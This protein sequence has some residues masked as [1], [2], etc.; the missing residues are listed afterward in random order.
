[1][2][3]YDKLLDQDYRFE[4]NHYLNE[5]WRLF[6]KGAGSFIGFTVLFFIISF[7]MNILFSLIPYSSVLGYI[8]QA[9]LS[10]GMFIFCRNLLNR[11]EDFGDFFKGF[12]SIGQLS[13]YMLTLFAFL[14]PFIFIFFYF[15][16]PIELLPDLMSGD[17]TSVSYAMEELLEKLSRNMPAILIV[18]L[19]LLGGI[20][21]VYISFAFVVPLIV[22]AK[23]DFWTAIKTSRAVIGKNFF[24]FLMMYI[25]LFFMSVLG[26]ILSCGLGL[27]VVVPYLS[28]VT[29]TAYDHIIKPQADD[30]SADLQAF[31]S[32]QKDINTESEDLTS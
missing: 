12:S 8:V 23:M 25:L 3:K 22:D 27:L 14:L 30:L 24:S 16:F 18:Y 7:V 9:A 2:N 15:I 11:R 21:Y 19:V 17:V 13:L 26:T 32:T 31:G 6:S 28:C 5:G 20:L 4:L 1:M 10:A 29:F